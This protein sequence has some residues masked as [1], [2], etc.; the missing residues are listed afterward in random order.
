VFSEHRTS[1]WHAQGQPPRTHFRH[2]QVGPAHYVLDGDHVLIHASTG[3]NP[4]LSTNGEI[5]ALHVDAFDADQRAGWSV[6]VT[7]A[8]REVANLVGAGTICR[9]RWLPA[10]GGNVIAVSTDLA[11][12]NVSDLPEV[13]MAITRSVGSFPLGFR[14]G[15]GVSALR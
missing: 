2:P 9:A 7:G 3:G 6:S 11:W 8:A 4:D 10:G 13:R 12:G 1:I 5:V 14:E 15:R